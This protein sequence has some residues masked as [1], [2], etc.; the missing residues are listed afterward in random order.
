MHPHQPSF[1]SR[2]WSVH[3]KFCPGNLVCVDGEVTGCGEIYLR[4]AMPT[5]PPILVKVSYLR[6]TL[7]RISPRRTC[8]RYQHLLFSKADSLVAADAIDPRH[9]ISLQS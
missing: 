7:Q 5:D 8:R 9:D 1:T 3:S 2:P 4:A 6:R